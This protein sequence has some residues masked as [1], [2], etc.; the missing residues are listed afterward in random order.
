MS[1]ILALRTLSPEKSQQRPEDFWSVMP[2]VFTSSE[3]C[4]S[5]IAML[6]AFSARTVMEV[7]LRALR[8]ALSAGVP[9]YPLLISLS[10]SAEMPPP[11]VWALTP[12]AMSSAAAAAAK[13]L[14]CIIS[15]VLLFQYVDDYAYLFLAAP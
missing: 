9:A 11:A 13:I 4:V 3:K 10:I 1:I 8:R 5:I 14:L 7:V 12:E 15:C 2:R 6:S